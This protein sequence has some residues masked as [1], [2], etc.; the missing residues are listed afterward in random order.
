M[1]QTSERATELQWRAESSPASMRRRSP[2]E[3]VADSSS[4]EPGGAP[5]D[6]CC[7]ATNE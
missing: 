7:I 2:A 3:R 1:H 4:F 5:P 6:P